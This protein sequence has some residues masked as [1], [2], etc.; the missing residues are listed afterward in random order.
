MGAFAVYGEG[1][2]AED[3]ADEAGDDAAV[4][5]A[6]AWAV[7]VEDADDAGVELVIGVVGHDHGFGEA[8]CFVV[9]AAG[10]DGVYVAPVGFGLGM[11]LGVAVD[12]AG[13]GEEKAGF[14]DFCEAEGF[15]GAEGA[16]FE[17]GDGHAEVVYGAGGAGEVED[18]VYFA[19]D[20]NVFG[21]V[22]VDE[23]EAGVPDVIYIGYGASDEVVH[24]DNMMTFGEKALAEMGAY[25]AGA[26]GDQGCGQESETSG[27]WLGLI[28]QSGGM[29]KARAKRGNGTGMLYGVGVVCF[30]FGDRRLRGIL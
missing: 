19:F 21:D 4:I 3:G 17:G 20:V 26:A 14:F 12:F 1:F 27:N 22:V 7:G 24:A 29:A 16:D 13:A 15:V 18:V 23:V 9:D 25:E 5:E 11:D 10:S 30:T 2:A 28:M 8:F 6:H